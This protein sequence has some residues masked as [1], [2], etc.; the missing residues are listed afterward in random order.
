M[1]SLNYTL[2]ITISYS[3]EGRLLSKIGN[4]DSVEMETRKIRLDLLSSSI[5]IPIDCIRSVE[6]IGH[7]TDT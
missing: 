7:D 4:V 5:D 2:P 1:D 6:R 3:K